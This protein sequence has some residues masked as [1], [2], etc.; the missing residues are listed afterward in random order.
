LNIAFSFQSGEVKPL[1]MEDEISGEAQ[2]VNAKPK[3]KAYRL[4]DGGALYLE[5][6]PYGGK[7]WR[8]KY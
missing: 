8:M 5:V 2:I 3:Q 1:L 4:A 6:S 7:Y